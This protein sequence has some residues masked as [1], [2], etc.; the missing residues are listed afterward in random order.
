MTFYS[1][2]HPKSPDCSLY[3]QFVTQ[4]KIHTTDSSITL[5]SNNINSRTGENI[6]IN[7]TPNGS[8]HTRRELIRN[9]HP[10]I[11]RATT[12]SLTYPYIFWLNQTLLCLDIMF[13]ITSSVTLC[14]CWNS[15]H[16]WGPRPKTTFRW[17]K[18]ETT[19]FHVMY[20]LCSLHDFGVCEH[21]SST[22]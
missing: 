12:Q 18:T 7:E 8:R 6:E 14:S 17:F 21:L 9:N 20:P 16:V 3:T 13:A 10:V 22:V 11:Y 19:K 4:G 2:L 15:N 1:Q 5:S